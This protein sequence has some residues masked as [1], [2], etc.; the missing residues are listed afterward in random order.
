[1]VS[2]KVGITSEPEVMPA[3]WFKPLPAATPL[4]GAT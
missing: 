3:C 2:A 4:W 1:M